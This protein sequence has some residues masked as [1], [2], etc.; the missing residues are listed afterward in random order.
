MKRF[1]LII[2]LPLTIILSGFANILPSR[3]ELNLDGKWSFIPFEMGKTTIDVPDYWDAKPGFV[4]T[5]QAIY[6]RE[7]TI[8]ATKE[9]ENKIFKLEFEGVNFIADVYVNNKLITSHIGG[10]IPFS[11]D[12]TE[13]VKPGIPFSLKVN[14]KG[15]SHQPIVDEKGAPQWPVGF[16]GQKQ[17]WG[18]IFDVWLR[19][20]GQVDIEDTYIQTSWRNKK[21]HID[22]EVINNSLNEKKI[23]VYGKVTPSINLKDVVFDLKS[24]QI[25]LKPGEK[26]TISMEKVW[27]NPQL[28]SPDNP[29][30]YYLQSEIVETDGISDIIVDKELRR[31][32]FREVWISG[33]KLMFNGHRMTL[34][35]TNLVQHSEFYDNQRYW[36][37]TP[38][39]WNSTIDRLME[40]NIRTVR[41]HMQPAPKFI[42]DIADERG[43]LV[44]DESTIYAREYILESNKN[45]YLENCKKWI[46]PWIKAARNH[47]SIV[48]WNAENEMGV[49]WL[50]WMT[51][52]EMKS[53]GDEIRKFD[54]TR[55]VN[56]DGDADVGDQ[57]VN[58]HYPEKYMENVKG[59]IYSWAD[60]VNPDKPTG[61]GE[62]IT[63]YGENGFD[64][65]WW[66]GTW[67]RGMRYVNF[68]DIRPYRHDW[69]LIRSDM[70]EKIQNLKNGFA[71]V[72]LFDKEYDNLGIDP[73]K[74]KNYP[75]LNSGDTVQRTLILYNDEFDDTIVSV[76]VIIKSSEIYQA[77]YSYNG[78]RT[79][80]ATI[81]AHGSR[82]YCLP[83][84]EHMDIPCSFQVPAIAEGF[85]DYVDIEYITR[86]R[87][88]VKF[89]ETKRFSLRNTKFTGKASSVVKLGDMQL[90][91]YH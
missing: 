48:V 36:Y 9:W 55:P 4:S 40:L 86:K 23:L 88:E 39:T 31:F 43:L 60:K 83:L 61:V 12:I 27:D 2:V 69:A 79:P 34:M 90:P 38:E 28:W 73:L 32:G 25:I 84:G 14:V 10:W 22:Y 42:L 3:T 8:P 91:E 62:F 26:R 87:G 35:G 6:E 70:D 16:T 45:I 89:R 85:A 67:V 7:I 63:H 80:I 47:P 81:V 59:S 24:E 21:I 56:Y 17:R 78:D 68:S 52:A 66:Q 33:N 82:T 15:G 46:E 75:Q 76:E 19:A 1:L 57:M 72:A 74:N 18:I 53:L 50:K 20:Y 41:F 44:I 77:L 29:Y 54:L 11:V 13:Y 64:N 71:R 5:D 49:G 58:L 51:S 37:M 65:Q 30:L